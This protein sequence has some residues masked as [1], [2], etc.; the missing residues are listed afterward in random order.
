MNGIKK[1]VV[2]AVV[3]AVIILLMIILRTVP[4]AKLWKGFS[5]LY[6]PADTDAKVVFDALDKYGCSDVISYY[7]QS[8]PFLN[9]YLPIKAD[10][11]DSYLSRR[12]SYFFDRDRKVMIYY[13]PDE[14]SSQAKKAAG[15]LA[16]ECMIDAG[17]DSK[18]SFPLVTPIICLIVAA[19]FFFLSK[20]KKVF[21][22]A[23]LFPIIYAFSM[24]FYVNAASVC[25]VLFAV[26][27]CQKVWR[28]KDGLKYVLRNKYVMILSFVSLVAAF[29]ASFV[30]GFLFM[31]AAVGSVLI[32]FMI[33]N[34]QSDYENSLRFNPTLIRPARFMKMICSETI[35]KG[36][37]VSAAVIVLF[38]LY[39]TSVSLF[40]ISNSQDLSFPMPTRY[41]TLTE[42]PNLDDYIVWSWNTA[43][44][45]YKSLN[46]SHSEVP[47][48]NECVTIQR[49]KD[50]D[51]GVKTTEEVVFKFDSDFKNEV[52]SSIDKLD[53]PAIEKLMK[54]QERG[55]SVDYSFGSGE[56][57]S[58]SNFI[59]M[60]I[61]IMV[62]CGMAIYY[63]G[64]KKRY[65][66]AY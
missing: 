56:K 64:E 61:M 16:G 41:N 36:L 65:G 30:S 2:P 43:T 57:F 54:M 34:M 62:P 5:V 14:Y 4:V 28:R 40:T 47:E 18:S 6:V 60:L 63:L 8:I 48:E 20:H 38:V 58:K 42:I 29:F 51:D 26:Y 3:S 23:S 27:L 59:M 13:I 37:I 7:N 52:I 19:V 45:P 46:A 33:N 25:L 66:N 53:Y 9:P 39:I 1:Y 35:N 49:F 15:F 11:S 12:N 24:P 44:L 10:Y 55:F 21:V 17:L 32:L 50:T 22:G 31:L